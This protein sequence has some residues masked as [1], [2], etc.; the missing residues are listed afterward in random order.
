MNY[1]Y[2]LGTFLHMKTNFKKLIENK[3]IKFLNQFQPVGRGKIGLHHSKILEKKNKKIK[4]FYVKALR[5]MTL[6]FLV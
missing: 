6:K 4:L 5:A 1:P 2:L 3:K